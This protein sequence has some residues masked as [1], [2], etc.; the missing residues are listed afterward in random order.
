MKRN[1]LYLLLLAAAL[2]SCTSN[3]KQSSGKPENDVDAARDFI[4]SSLDGKFNQAR[5]YLLQDSLNLQYMD[6]AERSYMKQSQDSI[7]A[8][9]GASIN[10][11]HVD[12]VNDSTTIIDFSNSFKNHPYKL[13]V[14]RLKGE[15]LVDLKY[16]FEQD[17]DTTSPAMLKVSQ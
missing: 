10:I 8:Y 6:V 4:R 3:D 1:P 17:R 16:L 7:N 5:T 12:P 2:G 15:W 11:H 14:V 9:R 13:K